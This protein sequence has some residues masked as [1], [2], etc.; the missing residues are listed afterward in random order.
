[1]AKESFNHRV[2]EKIRVPSVRLVGDNVEQ[3]VYETNE[4][5]KMATEMGMDLVEISPN[6]KPPVCKIIDY[7]KFL[8]QEKK[9]KKEM[10]KKNRENRVEVKELRFTPNTDSHDVGHKLNK[11]IEFLKSGDIVKAIVQFRGREM[12]NTEKGKILLLQFAEDLEEI[13]VPESLPRMEGRRMSIN[14]KPKKGKG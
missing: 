5:K 4:A 1:M 12:A 7:K 10:E 9:K 2:N 6:Q 11:A 13:G 8:Y 14:I 3:G